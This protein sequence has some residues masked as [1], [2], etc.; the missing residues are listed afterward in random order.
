MTL[1]ETLI[2]LRDNGPIAPHYGICWNASQL[3]GN[4]SFE[5]RICGLAEDWPGSAGSHSFPVEGCAG[6]Y[7]SDEGRNNR[8]NRSHP[9]GRRR[10]ALLDWLIADLEARQ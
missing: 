6:R 5:R 8:W 10:Y 4:D 7:S 1:L 3:S 2:R 9:Y